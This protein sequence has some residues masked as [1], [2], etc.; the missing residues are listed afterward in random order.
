MYSTKEIR[1]KRGQPSARLCPLG[2]T[3]SGKVETTARMDQHHTAFHH[4][5]R[6][7][8]ESATIRSQQ[9]ED[10]CLNDH[11]MLLLLLLLLY[12]LI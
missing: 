2:W 12:N 4:A 8:Q 5:Y 6:I 3:A 1:R 9:D 7:D 10:H 11:D